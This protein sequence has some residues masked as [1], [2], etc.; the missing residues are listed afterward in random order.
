MATDI[1]EI[2]ARLDEVKHQKKSPD[3]GIN[4]ATIWSDVYIED[5]AALLAEVEQLTKL[6]EADKA[7]IDTLRNNI[8]RYQL[9]LTQ[10]KAE[11]ADIGKRLKGLPDSQL[12][13]EHGL[14]AS[15]MI[16]YERLE[17]ENEALKQEIENAQFH[18]QG[19]EDGD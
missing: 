1:K 6:R 7:L 2:E 4:G 14:A 8:S 16:C 10:A 17:E 15:T 13:G 11:L 5:I 9:A 18:I 12:D 3:R 19:G